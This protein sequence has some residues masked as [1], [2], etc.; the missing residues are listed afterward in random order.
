M[1]RRRNPPPPVAKPAVEEP[2]PTGPLSKVG[3]IHTRLPRSSELP[4]LAGEL[5]RHRVAAGQDLL[6]IAR[7]GGLGF[8]ELRDANPR[9]DEWEPRPGTMILVPSRF[10]VPRTS[11]RG[12]VINIPEM[13]LYK[14]P[15]DS[16]PGEEVS[17]LTW[18]VGLGAEEVPSPIGEFEV[19]SKDTNPTWVV[20]DSIYRTMENPRRVVPPGPDNPL[21]D[22]RIRLNVDL[23]AIHGTNDP[24]TRR[25][26]HHPRLHP[27]LSRGHR[28]ALPDGG[29]WIS[30]RARLRAGQ[31]R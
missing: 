12:L 11:H 26:S 3:L 5:Q 27:P 13:R 1:C 10:I 7:D 4:G 20:P 9:I 22:Y 17:I 24:W 19:K 23:Y 14:F 8:R 21:G 2:A 16:R 15:L 29:S 6:T 28:H 31:A 18:P 30:R 25:P